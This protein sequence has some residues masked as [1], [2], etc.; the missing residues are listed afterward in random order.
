MSTVRERG[1]DDGEE[2]AGVGGRARTTLP[3]PMSTV[4]AREGAPGLVDEV[5]ELERNSRQP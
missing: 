1:F 2:A 5:G 3:S 4:E